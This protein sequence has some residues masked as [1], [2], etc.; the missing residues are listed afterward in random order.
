M[1]ILLVEGLSK[2]GPFLLPEHCI[3]IDSFVIQMK[4]LF[5]PSL[6]LCTRFRKK[7]LVYTFI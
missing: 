2:E 5:E 4:Q 7:R 1:T 6:C 3:E